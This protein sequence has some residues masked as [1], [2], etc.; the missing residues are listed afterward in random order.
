MKILLVHPGSKFYGGA[1]LVIVKLANYLVAHNHQVGLI[2]NHLPKEVTEQ[3]KDVRLIKAGGH[4]KISELLELWDF[5]RIYE[6]K[7]DLINV[8]NFPAT[9]TTFPVFRKPIVYTLNEPAEMFTTSL[10]KP[11]EAFNR[12][13][14]RH[15]VKNIVVAD[16]FNAKRCEDL[17]HIKPI[18]VP[19]G[20]DHDYF[21]QVKHEPDEDYFTVLQVGTITP[22]KNQL[23][24]IQAV[25]TLK[26]KIKNIRLILIG[27]ADNASY[28][29]QVEDAVRD[30]RL[31][32]K[33]DILPHANKEH[34]RHLYSIADVLL[35]P[36]QAQGGCLAPF[37]AISAG[38]PVI[39]SFELTCSDMVMKH[40]LGIVASDYAKAIYQLYQNYE[41]YEGLTVVARDWVRDNLSW[42]KYGE[43]M[44]K[45]FEKVMFKEGK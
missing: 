13:W 45:M 39:T 27:N 36:V 15:G 28:K 20:I 37:E 35:H 18:I 7:Y 17:Y 21:S 2:Y 19:Y 38:C 40:N 42:D 34:I 10:R 25:G 30:L 43:N 5:T 3:L 32:G 31:G 6:S 23:A 14:L 8:H 33:V 41:L 16:T 4:G 44:V 22:Y 29:H 9:A 24:T 11:L 1:E 26:D 12:W